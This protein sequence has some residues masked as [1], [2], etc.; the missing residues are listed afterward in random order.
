MIL[1][2][3]LVLSVALVPAG[4][5]SLRRLTQ[6]RFRSP[7]LLWLALG[8]QLVLMAFPGPET[9]WRVAANVA[10]YPLG[11]GWVWMNRHVPGLWV[12]GIGALLNV[13]PMLA[14]GGVMPAS[15]D[16]L[17]TAGMPVDAA[18][19]TNS[20]V[21]ESPKLLFLGDVLAIPRSWPFA[22][23]LSAGDVVIALGAAY[24]IHRVSGS[25]LAGRTAPARG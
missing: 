15:A 24:V 12:V 16:A 2:V 14:N 10:T 25:R 11:I 7:W 22:N 23:V 3:F 4:G 5:G 19:F 8:A 1:V 6:I 9:G 18:V 21:L 17:R 13:L 20:T